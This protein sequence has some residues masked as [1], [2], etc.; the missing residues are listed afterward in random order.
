MA[1]TER[2][3]RGEAGALLAAIDCGAPEILRLSEWMAEHPENSLEERE[4][5][6]RDRAYL[7]ARGFALRTGVAGLETAFVAERGSAREAPCVALLSEMDARP[8]IG[9]ACGHDLSGPAEA[10]TGCSVRWN[11]GHFPTKLRPPGGWAMRG[12]GAAGRS[13]LV[14][15]RR[16]M[17]ESLGRSGVRDARVLEALAA[18][19]RHR[20]VPDALRD[21]AYRDASL[22][23]GDGQTI[24]AP[25]VVAAMTEALE[26]GGHERILEVG[27]GSGYQAAVLARL[28]DSVISIERLPRLA[29]QA[30]TNLDRLGVTNVVVH[31]GDGSVGRPREAP[32]DA[33]VVTAAGREIPEPLLAQLGPEGRLVGP[34]GDRG[35]QR[36]VRVR[37]VASGGLV[38]E[39]LGHCRFVELVGAHG[40]EA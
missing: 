6:A 17:A 5:A 10:A 24:S 19:P 3:P 7:E 28:A 13:E 21:E 14:R 26:L 32:F 36:L 40:W 25:S 33:I 27:T 1:E 31:L 11:S 34:F 20:L 18:V 12:S 35:A 2:T 16:R 15:P 29:A 39:V 38:R 8:A 22:P 23:I 4:T 9:H 37:R 30:R